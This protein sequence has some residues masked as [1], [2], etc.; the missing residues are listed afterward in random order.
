MMIGL[1]QLLKQ[2]KYTWD[3][4]KQ[5]YK[6]CLVFNMIIFVKFP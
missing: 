1:R 4:S 5:K 2:E 3:V 6:I